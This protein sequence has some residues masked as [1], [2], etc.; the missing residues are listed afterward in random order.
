MLQL[1]RALKEKEGSVIATCRTVSENLKQ[2]GV[3]VVEGEPLARVTGA[4]A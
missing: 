2:A 3:E 4:G 1:C